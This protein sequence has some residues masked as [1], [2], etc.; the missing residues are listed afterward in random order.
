MDIDPDSD[1]EIVS[2]T[3]G[4][5]NIEKFKRQKTTMEP[6]KSTPAEFDTVQCRSGPKNLKCKVI[7]LSFHSNFQF[8]NFANSFR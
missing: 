3:D 5:Q 8:L 2:E 6:H 1:L 7:L 4:N